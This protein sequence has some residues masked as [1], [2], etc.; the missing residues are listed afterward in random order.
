[1]NITPR[2]DLA[3]AL[4]G[5]GGFNLHGA[6]ILASLKQLG[7]TPDLFTVT[8]GQIILLAEYLAGRDPAEQLLRHHAGRGG[9][10]AALKTALRGHSGVFR[11]AAGDNLLSWM[12]NM[13]LTPMAA[14]ERLVSARQYIPV[15]SRDSFIETAEILN[16]ASS[17]V[18]FNTF[19]FRTGQGILHGNARAAELLPADI[20][21]EPITS[22]SIES[23]LWLCQYGFED[24]P[25]GRIDG[26]YHRSVILAEL[27]GFRH[28]VAG[29][30]FPIALGDNVPS[31]T[32]DTEDWKIKQWFSN[33]CRA[34][35]ARL[36]RT[37]ELIG[38][39]KVQ[40]PDYAVERLTELTV[41]SKW[42]LFNYF[43][44]KRQVYEES[45]EDA[46]A[47]LA[48]GGQTTEAAMNLSARLSA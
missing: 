20:A 8:S 41:R 14:V 1:M 21:I 30:P 42:G 16:A 11:S 27:H 32:F 18:V 25:D 7:M 23:A 44:E 40:D 45:L 5:F 48:D 31:T 43:G 3:I 35:I 28:V 47:A 2:R 37:I 10:T 24:A 46:L 19:D 9:P 12:S 22:R 29:I 13:P 26:A 34:E 39:W 33:S 38:R 6:G 15:R 36:R 4:G 17:G